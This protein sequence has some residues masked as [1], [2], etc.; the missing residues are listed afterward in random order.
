MRVIP[1]IT[2]SN[3]VLIHRSS[4]LNRKYL[5]DPLNALIQYCDHGCHELCWFDV[6]GSISSQTW[7]GISSVIDLT[8]IPLA[9]GGGIRTVK[10]IELLASRGVEKL[11]F[12]LAVADQT[13][14]S[15]ASRI[16][17]SQ[18]IIVSVDLW[19]LSNH[20]EAD[21]L[22]TGD[23][24]P[25]TWLEKVELLDGLFGELLLKSIQYSGAEKGVDPAIM[26]LDIPDSLQITELAYSGG[27][28]S[29][30]DLDL[31]SGRGFT[32]GYVSTAACFSGDSS[33]SVL[34][35]WPF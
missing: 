4:F 23:S 13:L 31:L 32:A 2:T 29:Q 30:A 19:T 22:G 34:I 12:N 24:V 28:A 9:Y 5:G 26:E 14:I 15:E 35:H 8:S 21:F 1:C 16:L 27:I 7:I 17:G 10:D 25:I 33:N 11:V 6:D 3:G 18:S 20:Y